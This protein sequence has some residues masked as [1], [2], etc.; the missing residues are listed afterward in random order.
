M[1]PG[2][3][4]D[5]VASLDGNIKDAE[6]RIVK[7]QDE[8]AKT[9]TEIAGALAKSGVELTPDQV[10]L[11]L[12]SVLSGDLVRL[13]AVF[14]AAKVIDTQLGKLLDRRRR[15]H[16]LG[17]QVLR[18]ARGAVRHAGARA[19]LGDRE[20]RH[21]L[22]AQ[23]RCHPEGHHQRTGKTAKLL[24]G[25]N[26]PDQKRALEAN[27]DAQKVAAE[28][29]K[30]YRRYLQQQ[31]EQIAKARTRAVHDLRIADNT[32]E[33]VEASFQLKNLMRDSAAS[34]E[35]IQ[36]LEA[37]TFDQI[38]KNEELRQEFENL[39]RRLDAPSS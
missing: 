22:H 24:Q 18:H 30:G 34:F 3:L 8:I 25:E 13:V 35:A 6:Q 20:D 5:T 23:A 4:N 32:Y 14:N 19:G 36:K 28:A 33:T 16:E 2:V 29:A 31:R 38:F 26:R 1:L 21:Q 7:N 17:A 12:D 37:P 27:R 39:T 11:L 15:Q 9:K 10:D